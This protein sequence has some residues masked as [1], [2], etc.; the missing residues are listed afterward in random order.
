M[1][2]Q[3]L[4]LA[5]VFAAGPQQ[6]R[7][8][9][10]TSKAADTT[11]KAI[12]EFE[13]RLKQYRELHKKAES[14]APPIDKKKEDP[15]SIVAHEQAVSSAIRAS[16]KNAAEGDIFTPAVQKLLV[17]TIAR[18][19]SPA[20]GIRGRTAK[21]MILGEGNP[22][23]PESKAQIVLAVNAKYPEHAPL[24]TVPPSVLLK[25]PTLP[26]G[27]EYRFVGRHLILY[28]LKANLIVDILRNAIR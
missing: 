2:L 16:R 21:E 25:L 8:A 14:A 3:G 13:D 17:A 9:D 20:R 6:S 1:F 19:L 18:E 4:A 24:S 5:I 28:D 26:E 7:P 22:R 15:K 23:H 11:N 10:T 27:L 12:D